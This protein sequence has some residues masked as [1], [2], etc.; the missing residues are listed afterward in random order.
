[1]LDTNNKAVSM[2]AIQSK[3]LILLFWDPDCG[4]CEKEIP[5]MKEFYD[6]NKEKYGLEI[7]TVCSDTSLVKWKK[8]LIKRQMN[9]INVNGP[10]TYTGNYHDQYDITT[11]P[12]IFILNE[13]KEI[14]AKR[15]GV[16]QFSQFFSNY[17]KM[18]ARKQE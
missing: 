8:A 2:H 13:K 14:I 6:Q 4:H 12:V 16:D 9:W 18:A 15:V 10:R 1:M 17:V 3:F 7:F 11:S 5:K